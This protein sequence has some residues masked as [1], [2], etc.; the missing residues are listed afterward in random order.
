[1]T[2]NGNTL[3]SISENSTPIDLDINY[4]IIGAGNPTITV[5]FFETYTNSLPEG[6]TT[7]TFTFSAGDPD[8]IVVTVTAIIN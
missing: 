3:V 2:L 5:R 1:V 7:F 4:E 8:S 6:T